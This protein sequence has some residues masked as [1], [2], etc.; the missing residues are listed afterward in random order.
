MSLNAPSTALL[1]DR[2]VADLLDVNTRT[3]ANWRA[4]RTH[5]PFVRIGHAVRYN[6]S[7]IAAY[8]ERSRVQPHEMSARDQAQK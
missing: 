1:R 2:A 7:D 6:A 4:A 3:L 8:L 5:L